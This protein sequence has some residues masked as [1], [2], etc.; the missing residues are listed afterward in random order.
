MA[1]R[2]LFYACRAEGPGNSIEAGYFVNSAFDRHI[3]PEH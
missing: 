3:D 2:R 1:F